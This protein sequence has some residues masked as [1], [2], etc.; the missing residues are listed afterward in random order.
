[1]S[2]RRLAQHLYD[3]V[4]HPHHHRFSSV[5]LAVAPAY[6][7]SP[8]P[9]QPCAKDQDHNPI[10]VGSVAVREARDVSRTQHV[11]DACH[12]ANTARN[13]LW[14]MLSSRATVV[15]GPV[16]TVPRHSIA[17]KL[18]TILP[19]TPFNLRSDAWFKK[20]FV[21]CIR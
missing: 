12:I 13:A 1:M 5:T 4:H 20:A 11:S 2:S 21:L 16:V 17:G 18:A 6:A 14:C 19:P 3:H 8:R 9:C 10:Q 7:Q 15:G